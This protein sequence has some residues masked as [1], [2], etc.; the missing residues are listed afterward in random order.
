MKARVIGTLLAGALLASC[1][2]DDA[3][4]GAAAGNGGEPSSE[5]TSTITMRDDEFVPSTAT[6]AV[7]DV[8][9]VNEGESPHNFTIEGQGVD[10]D[11]DPGTTTTQPIDLAAGTYTIF[12][13]FHRSDGMQG[14]LTVEG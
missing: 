9:L 6:I 5:T 14:S 4:G 10:V 2:G 3:G 13:A 8:E 11:V 12:C 1:G 7:G